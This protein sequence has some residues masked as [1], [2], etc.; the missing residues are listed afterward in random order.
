MPRDSV[1]E[2][3]KKG[4]HKNTASFLNKFQVEELNN[5]A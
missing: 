3:A 5:R 1:H 4:T 2:A